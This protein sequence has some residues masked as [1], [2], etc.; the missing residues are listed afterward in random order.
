MTADRARQRSG[1]VAAAPFGTVTLRDVARE[2][3]VSSMTVS[4]VV[5]GKF[6]SMSDGTR[7]RVVEAIAALGYR[8]HSA[9]RHLKLARRFS[10]GML[11]VDESPRFLADPFITELVAGLS[12]HLG[13]QGYDIVL[14]GMRSDQLRR[15]TLI[16]NVRTDGLCVLLSGGRG[17]RVAAL[18]VLHRLR[19]PMVLFQ[20]TVA[21]AGADMCSV[22]Q[23]DREGG[24]MLASLLLGGG[25]RELVM[26]IPELKWPA[27]GERVAGVREAIA[28]SGTDARLT[29][30][31]TA[32]GFEDMQAAVAAHIETHGVPDAVL[33]GNDQIGFAVT[34][35]LTARGL[36][37]P[38]DVRVTGFNAFEFWRY[39][40]VMLTT[41]RS[42]AYQLGE[43]GGAEILA[44][45]E[46]GAFPDRDVVLPVE[47]CLGR[48]TC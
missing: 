25:D 3:G 22:R 34:K 15:S 42:P 5:R 32:N 4:N 27:I 18:E 36:A 6:G 31:P 10:V 44:R 41:V 16:Q 1:Y 21:N 39:S 45:L 43:R 24:R 20:E 9:A 30:V 28:G 35:Y 12:N 17:E 37:V 29:I 13:E 14:Q 8:P 2:A 48:T 38:E 19:Q 33:A 40:D 11:V 46:E 7:A 47:L 26:M 23:D